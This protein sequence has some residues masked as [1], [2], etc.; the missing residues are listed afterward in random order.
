MPDADHMPRGGL[1][2]ERLESLVA[3]DLSVRQIAVEVDRGPS[4]VR[5]WLRRHGL[6]TTKAARRTARRAQETTGT[7]IHHGPGPHI[8]RSDGRSTCARCRADAVSRWR[9]RAKQ[10]LVDEAGGAC[11]ICGYSRCL[12][13]LQFHHRDPATK[14]FGIGSRGLARNIESLR[15]EAAKCILLCSNCHAEVEDGMLSVANVPIAGDR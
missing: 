3:Q 9:R 6:E 7:C 13:A 4:T 15:E 11:Q 12:R 1:S 8:R 2:R 10:T 5:Y 14:R